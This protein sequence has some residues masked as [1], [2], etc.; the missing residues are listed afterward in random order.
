MKPKTQKILTTLIAAGLSLYATPRGFSHENETG[1]DHQR[2]GHVEGSERL[3]QKTRLTATADAP[4]GAKGHVELRATNI[5]GVSAAMLKL[6][7]EGLLPGTYSVSVTSL[8]DATVITPLGSFDVV[9]SAGE[10]GDDGNED[11][12]E[13]HHDSA[14]PPPPPGVEP[15]PTGG[16]H[17][18]G[19]GED[20]ESSVVFGG[21]NGTPFPDGFNPLDIGSITLSDANGLA[22]LTGSFASAPASAFTA[23]VQVE[24][25]VDAPAANG[26]AVVRARV[27][28][29]TLSQRFVLAAGGLPANT[30]VTV[31]F[32]GTQTI[33]TRTSAK[34]NLGVTRLPRGVAGH[35]LTTVEI[36]GQQGEQL[37]S[38]HF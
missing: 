23:T 36:A 35:H 37:G 2:G 28:K 9:A 29:N 10:S 14:A 3:E 5:N 22:L 1:D 34:G 4:G 31:T 6:E 15:T 24:P 13:D 21:K 25:G 8:A 38:V 30:P 7:V 17:H 12:D 11:A 18:D 33:R 27:K 32:N 20:G 19:H 26:R 16:E